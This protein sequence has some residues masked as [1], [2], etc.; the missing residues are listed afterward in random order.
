MRC[1]FVFALGGNVIAVKPVLQALVLAERVYTDKTD[2]HIICGTFTA[3]TI[4]R[5][6][7][8]TVE[9]P[10]GQNRPA[11]VG[12][13]DGGSPYAYISVTDV[14]GRAEL[15]LQFVNLTKNE[16]VFQT[17]LEVQ[18]EERLETVEIIAPLPSLTP[19]FG[20]IG[21]GK[22]ICAF[23]VVCESEI[24]GSHRLIVEVTE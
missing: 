20:S 13:V 8:E 6:S 7:V 23:E 19:Y 24:L 1:G 2:R 22:F 10:D 14:V 21:Q 17:I 18:C 4:G 11:I 16:V 5:M 3:I 9:T 12:G 15:L